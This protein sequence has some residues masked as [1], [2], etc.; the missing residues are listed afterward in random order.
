MKS[1][2]RFLLPLSIVANLVLFGVVLSQRSSPSNDSADSGHAGSPTTQSAA[3]S[4]SKPDRG[5]STWQSLVTGEEPTDWVKSLRAAGFPDSV[6]NAVVSAQ[7]HERYA[8]RRAALQQKNVDQFWSKT[9]NSWGGGDP[10]TRAAL[11]A[12]GREERAEIKRALG[13]AYAAHPEYQRAMQRQFGDIPKEKIDALQ[14]INEDYQELT[15][16]I[17]QSANGYMLPEDREKL[18]FLEKEKRADL[19][20]ILTPQELQDYELR[21]SQTANSLRWQLT[22]FDPSEQEFRAI[23]DLQREFDLE[24]SNHRSNTDEAANELRRTAEAALQEQIKTTLG[25]A[26]YAEYQRAKDHN[27]QQ[28]ANLAQRLE[29]PKENAVAVYDLSK[30]VEK[31][32]QQIRGN[33]KLTT[34]ARNEAL[35]ALA[36]EANAKVV[37]ALGERGAEAYKENSGWWLRNL[38][39]RPARK[40]TAK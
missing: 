21:T 14:I 2:S 17:H 6:I 22:A 3:G 40:S 25:E 39:P 30:D 29:L 8:A 23:F 31:R 37:D 13:D 11:R 24:F 7:I 35:A 9:W 26:R 16:E 5:A 12:L 28:L 15:S 4:V 19:A 27:Y 32:A 20:A 34:D 36:E 10:E 38:V 33:S 1:A 18:A